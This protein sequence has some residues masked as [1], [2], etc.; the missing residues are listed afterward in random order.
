MRCRDHIRCGP[1]QALAALLLLTGVTGCGGGNPVTGKVTFEDGSP[2]D[3]GTVAA[4]K[5]EGDAS[6]S[7]QGTIQPDGTYSL[8]TKK[9]GSGVP[10]GHYRVLVLPPDLTDKQLEAGM[11]DPIASKWSKFETSGLELDVK[12]GKN[13]FNI[14]VTRGGNPVTG[15]VTFEDGSPLDRGTVMAEKR[16]GTAVVSAQGEIQPDGTYFLGTDTP[17]SGAPAGHYRVLVAPPTGEDKQ[18][19]SDLLD[20]KW[21]K[22]ETSGLELDVKSGKNEFNITVTKP[23]DSR[24]P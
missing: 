9:P 7:A 11:A 18:P 2:L 3:R 22:L 12:G 17:G 24:S 13:E 4:E 10:A 15:K 14:T 23:S 5:R 19:E 21:T 1:L 8:G 16:E 6:V 20:S